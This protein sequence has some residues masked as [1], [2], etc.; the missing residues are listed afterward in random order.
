MHTSNT[1]SVPLFISLPHSP[2]SSLNHLFF[3]SLL[4]KTLFSLLGDLPSRRLCFSKLRRIHPVAHDDIVC[5]AN[6]AGSY[7]SL[8]F[9]TRNNRNETWVKT[10]SVENES[11]TKTDL[12]AECGLLLNGVSPFLHSS[13]WRCVRG[14]LHRRSLWWIQL[15]QHVQQNPSRS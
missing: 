1:F 10:G 6:S 5:S 2:C 15:C 3:N 13:H 9:A 12:V 7:F 14:H 4:F 8:F 11:W